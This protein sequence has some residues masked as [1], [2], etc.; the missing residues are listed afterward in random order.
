MFEIAAIIFV[1]CAGLTSTTVNA[2]ITVIL[3]LRLL[4]Q[5]VLGL[6]D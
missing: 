4:L 5:I 1:W 3:G 6:K 2:I